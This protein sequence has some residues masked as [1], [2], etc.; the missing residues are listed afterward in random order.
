[1]PLLKGLPFETGGAPRVLILGSFPSTLSLEA[2]T[3]YANP[4]NQFWKIMEYHLGIPEN[5]PYPEKLAFLKNNNIGL[6]DVIF[7]CERRGAMDNSIRHA[8]L[9]DIPLFLKAHPSVR[10]VIANGTTAGRYLKQ[11]RSGWPSG[12]TFHTLPSTSPANAR[13][14]F[15]EKIQAWAVILDGMGRP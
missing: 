7:S 3:Y 12:V 1:M 11:F 15:L 10:I 6:W 4:R 14:R 8:T 2:G 5:S 9:N 13:A